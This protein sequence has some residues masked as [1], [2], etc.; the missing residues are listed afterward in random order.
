MNVKQISTGEIVYQDLPVKD[1]ILGVSDDDN[2]TVVIL[3]SGDT[4]ALSPGTDYLV[5]DAA[6]DNETNDV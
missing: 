2:R 5:Y 3:D 4:V 1:V 6:A